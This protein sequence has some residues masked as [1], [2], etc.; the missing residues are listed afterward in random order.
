VDRQ[1][2]GPVRAELRDALS[3]LS[4]GEV[5]DPQLVAEALLEPDAATLIVTLAE[6]RA[7]LRDSTGEPS[8]AFS[9]RVQ[10]AL[11]AEGR[12]GLVLVRR[13]TPALCA[14]LGLTAGILVGVMFAPAGTA[15]APATVSRPVTPAVV[16]AASPTPL[17]SAPTAVAPPA[18]SVYRFE[19]GRNWREGS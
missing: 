8:D 15:P 19:V 9:A 14:G 13:F 17:P 6:A 7:S 10:Q 2:E 4:D 5:A 12:P 1:K 16:T 3:A 11:A 18:K